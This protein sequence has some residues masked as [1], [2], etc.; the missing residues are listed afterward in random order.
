[1]LVI[2]IAHLD[3]LSKTGELKGLYDFT[4]QTNL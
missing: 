3:K 4:G 1:M 2:K